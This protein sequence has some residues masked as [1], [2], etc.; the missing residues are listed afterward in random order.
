MSWRAVAAVLIAVFFYVVLQSAMA[1]PLVQIGNELNETTEME[2][3]H[4][5]DSTFTSLPRAWFNMGLIGIFLG[6]VW[7]LARVVRR[8][9]TR[10][11][12]GGL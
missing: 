8:E 5:D 4:F 12:G 11:G 1:G 2:S 3:E 7:G 10:G 9:L 6:M